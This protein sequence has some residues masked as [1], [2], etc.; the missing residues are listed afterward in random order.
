MAD[1]TERTITIDAPQSAVMAGIADFEAYPEWSPEIKKVEIRERDELGRGSAVYYEVAAGP[2]TAKYTLS[3]TY[4]PN[5]GGVTWTFVEGSGIKDMDGE[6]RLEPDGSG[7]KVTYTLT[8]DVPIPG[9][10]F[11]KKKLLAEGEKRII[12]TALKGLKGRVE[13]R[14]KGA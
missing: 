11:I 4:S 14:L 12:H 13:S 10:G 9:P 3:Y 7:T 5:D 1:L 2:I 8:L 6:Y